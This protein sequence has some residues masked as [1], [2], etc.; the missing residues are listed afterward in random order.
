MK[1]K[2]KF[3]RIFFGKLLDMPA[4]I[5]QG[6][7]EYTRPVPISHLLPNRDFKVI[8]AVGELK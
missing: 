3:K 5:Q 8:F 7:V 6:M 4:E 2:E 1:S